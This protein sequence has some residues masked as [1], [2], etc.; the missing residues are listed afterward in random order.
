VVEELVGQ[1]YPGLQQRW[2]ELRA[3]LREQKTEV[4]MSEYGM[5]PTL[6]FSDTKHIFFV[7]FFVC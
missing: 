2:D 5:S 3:L 7:L 4:D 6:I 1:M